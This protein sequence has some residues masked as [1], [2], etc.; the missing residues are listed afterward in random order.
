MITK[1]AVD[2]IVLASGSTGRRGVLENIGLAFTVVTSDIDEASV[3]RSS[4]PELVQALAQAKARA[5]AAPQEA[6]LVIG[7]DNLVVIAD[8]RLGKPEGQQGATQMLKRLGGSWHSIFNGMTV[9]NTVTNKE[10]TGFVVTRVKF[11]NLS[12]EEIAAYVA[13][14]EPMDKAGAYG[15]QGKGALLVE[16][17]EGD[18]YGIVGMSVALLNQLAGQVGVNIGDF[19]G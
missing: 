11:R 19:L 3:E 16:R 4:T 18:Y 8:A 15:I 10:A 17:I 7:S 5:V 12:E 9:I 1:Q 13:S 2:K 14:G 6:A